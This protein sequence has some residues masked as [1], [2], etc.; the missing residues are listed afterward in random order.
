MRKVSGGGN[1]AE[2]MYIVGEPNIE[3][4]LAVGPSSVILLW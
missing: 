3:G 1:A 2:P 4:Q